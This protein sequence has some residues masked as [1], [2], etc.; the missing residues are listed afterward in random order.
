LG[1]D[2]RHVSSSLRG[3]KNSDGMNLRC[4]NELPGLIGSML[5]IASDY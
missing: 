3:W 1:V 4:S 5:S 2:Q